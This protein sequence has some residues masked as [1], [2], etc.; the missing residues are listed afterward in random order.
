[1]RKG[2]Y[3]LVTNV[4][5][6]L[7]HDMH[8]RANALLMYDRGDGGSN[9]APQCRI[10]GFQYDPSLEVFDLELPSLAYQLGPDDRSLSI[11]HLLARPSVPEKRFMIER[12]V[13]EDSH[14]ITGI[15]ETLKLRVISFLPPNRAIPV[16]VWTPIT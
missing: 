12:F 15:W 14:T 4:E 10:R 7:F 8:I 9:M 6:V 16:P 13:E 2:V 11:G 5:H 1:M 3:I